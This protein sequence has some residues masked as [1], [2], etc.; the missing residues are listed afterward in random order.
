MGRP[1]YKIKENEL[2]LYLYEDKTVKK[3]IKQ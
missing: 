1:V 3:I 2:Y